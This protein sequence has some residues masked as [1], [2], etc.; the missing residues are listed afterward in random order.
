MLKSQRKSSKISSSSCNKQ[1]INKNEAQ[2]AKMRSDRPKTTFWTCIIAKIPMKFIKLANSSQFSRE[3]KQQRAIDRHF[4]REQK[5]RVYLPDSW[6][7]NK[8]GSGGREIFVKLNFLLEVIIHN[9][10]RIVRDFLA[11]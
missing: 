2:Q 10:K 9:N 7:K 11:G 1:C 5:A 8:K 6:I 4:D 3:K